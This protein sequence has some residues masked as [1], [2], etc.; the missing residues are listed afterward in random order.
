MLETG[1]PLRRGVPQSALQRLYVLAQ[2]VYRAFPGITE[3]QMR[4]YYAADTLIR[5]ASHT[6]FKQ[7]TARNTTLSEYA[8]ISL[9]NDVALALQQNTFTEEEE[10]SMLSELRSKLDLLTERAKEEKKAK[11]GLTAA[12]AALA[13]P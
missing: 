8:G 2:R 1:K 6:M 13:A 10:L 12:A 5:E 11:S 3:A 4:E 7:L 9:V